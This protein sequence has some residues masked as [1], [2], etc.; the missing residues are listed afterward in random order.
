MENDGCACSTCSIVCIARHPPLLFNSNGLSFFKVMTGEFTSFLEIPWKFAGEMQD[1]VC[2]DAHLIGLNGRLWPTKLCVNNGL[3]NFRNGWEKFVSD[4]CLN[5]G[6]IVVFRHVTR[7][8]FVV[9]IFRANGY[10]K[11]CAK[12]EIPTGVCNHGGKSC[13]CLEI[14]HIEEENNETSRII[15]ATEEQ[16]TE[17]ELACNP[18]AVK[19]SAEP[20]LVLE[21]EHRVY[22]LQTPCKEKK[23]KRKKVQKA[24]NSSCTARKRNVKK[25]QESQ[26]AL[27][28]TKKEISSKSFLAEVMNLVITENPKFGKSMSDSSVR[29]GYRLSIPKDFGRQWLQNQHDVVLHS[30]ELSESW[31]A[32]LH[33]YTNYYGFAS[34]WRDFALEHNLKEKDACV[35]ELVDKKRRIFKVH[36]FRWE[37]FQ[38]QKLL[39]R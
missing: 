37:D 27:T 21:M 24:Q 1:G 9:Q 33:S 39:K 7:T 22:R 13:A 26:N 25:V 35:F 16:D 3:A 14:I 34:E 10:E 6:E 32:R 5:D 29:D 15:T 23:T 18:A 4:N 19:N 12:E 28:L 2:R 17:L 11:P 30:H 20:A 31:V 8:D 36:V 38:R